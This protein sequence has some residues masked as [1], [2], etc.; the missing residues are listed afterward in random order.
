MQ[1]QFCWKAVHLVGYR[2]ETIRLDIGR[3]HRERGKASASSAPPTSR[4]KKLQKILPPYSRVFLPI[5]V[6]INRSIMKAIQVKEYLS[7]PQDLTVTTLPDPIPK[8]DEYLI[9]IHAAA[10]NFFD[11]LQM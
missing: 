6:P 3:V 7:G 4:Q 11:L 2:Q 5:L 10:T 8:P 1:D 9:R